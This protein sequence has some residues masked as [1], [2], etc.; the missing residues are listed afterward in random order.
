MRGHRTRNQDRALLIRKDDRYG[1]AQGLVTD[2]VS[3][4]GGVGSA[5]LLQQATDFRFLF[6]AQFE[7]TIESFDSRFDSH[8]LRALHPFDAILACLPHP[9]GVQAVGSLGFRRGRQGQRQSDQQHEG[10][11]QFHCSS[12]LLVKRRSQRPVH[13]CPRGEPAGPRTRS[14]DPLLNA[15]ISAVTHRRSPMRLSL[16]LL[17]ALVAHPLRAQP[18]I[19]V[20]P[21]V[22]I[23]G[24][25]ASAE[26]DF[27]NSTARRSR[28]SKPSRR[29]EIWSRRT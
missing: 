14:S 25:G 15:L 22:S 10:W 17:F 5:M 20:G 4:I 29:I 6:V 11:I 7:A 16:L 18:A 19:Y 2:L 13:S 12:S 23:L 8:L 21:Q 1:V 27:G 24:I 3:G 28:S 9:L 26:A